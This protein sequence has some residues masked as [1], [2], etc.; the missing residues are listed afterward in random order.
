MP[1]SVRP[2]R[3]ACFVTERAAFLFGGA[4]PYH[5][6]LAAAERVAEAL[7]QHR[8]ACADGLCPGGLLQRGTR[9]AD[10]DEKVGIL[11]PAGPPRRPPGGT[12]FR[13]CRQRCD[14]LLWPAN[15]VAPRTSWH[16]SGAPGLPGR[17]RPTGHGHHPGT[18]LATRLRGKGLH[19]MVALGMLAGVG[20]KLPPAPPGGIAAGP[21]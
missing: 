11:L 4:A 15:S 20:R 1:S 17:V 2:G 7:G 8:A 3:K 9:R 19:R 21:P 18:T 6:V 12:Q 5:A 16:E 10:G 14:H 13:A